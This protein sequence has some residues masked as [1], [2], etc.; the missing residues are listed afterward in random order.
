M[1]RGLRDEALGLLRDAAGWRLAAGRWPVVERRLDA[2]TV[3]LAAGDFAAF[4]A[5]ARDLE[6]D[7]PVRATRIEDVPPQPAPTP[8]RERINELVHSL[9]GPVPDGAGARAGRDGDAAG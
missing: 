2:M 4:A 8:V 3:A 6:A 1:D 9:A 7:G 5:A